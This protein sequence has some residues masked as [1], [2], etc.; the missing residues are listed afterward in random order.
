MVAAPMLAMVGDEWTCTLWRRQGSLSGKINC[1]KN[2]APADEYTDGTAN[3][4]QQVSQWNQCLLDIK[5]T[6]EPSLGSLWE[7]QPW[8]LVR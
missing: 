4:E 5:Q 3:G 6:L 7:D 8:P 2:A 1:P